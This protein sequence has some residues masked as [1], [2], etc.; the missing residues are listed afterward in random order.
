MGPETYSYCQS[1]L[2]TDS[3]QLSVKWYLFIMA[4]S[5]S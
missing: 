3:L 4:S 2:D 1:V 5:V